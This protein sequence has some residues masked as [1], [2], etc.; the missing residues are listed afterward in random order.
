MYDEGNKKSVEWIPTMRHKYSTLFFTIT[1]IASLSFI[2]LTGLAQGNDVLPNI[3]IGN[4]MDSLENGQ[5]KAYTLQVNTA[6]IVSVQLL[7]LTD[8]FE[9]DFEFWADDIKMPNILDPLTNEQV[10]TKVALPLAGAYTFL[11]TDG[12][13]EVRGGDFVISI[14]FVGEYMENENPIPVDATVTASMTDD[15]ML[16]RHWFTANPEQ[17][18]VLYVQTNETN[19]DMRAS[20]RNVTRT[21]DVGSATFPLGSAAFCIPAGSDNY[22]V[23]IM[24]EDDTGVT[25][26]LALT[27]HNML[28]CGDNSTNSIISTLPSAAANEGTAPLMSVPSMPDEEFIVNYNDCIAIP[29]HE[30]N[31]RQIPS[32]SADIVTRAHPENIPNVIG[33][34]RGRQWVYVEMPDGR[35][36][37]IYAG[38]VDLAEAC[39]TL[40][41]PDIPVDQAYL[42]LIE[43]NQDDSVADIDFDVTGDSIN[44]DGVA[45]TIDT[46]TTVD[47][48][49]VN[50]VVD[51]V[52][53]DVVDDVVDIIVNDVVE[54][55]VD[56]I[57]QLPPLPGLGD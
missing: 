31:V 6:Q 8:G 26:H 10:D 46:V 15:S 52:I 21:R 12:F 55:V 36:G 16:H 48:G 17:D 34:A 18:L 14:Q 11:V 1:I 45:R 24:N 51:T 29:T 22:W 9:P 37:F 39:I 20:V 53:D 42:D 4:H 35:S 25:Y 38:I 5:S 28:T 33:W 56:D 41:L 27:T 13:G 19:M 54:T 49:A 30:I 47:T 32:T 43:F 23:D 57:I 7:S 50:D 40:G 3:T 2:S 44:V